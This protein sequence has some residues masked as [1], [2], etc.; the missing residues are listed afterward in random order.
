VTEY[1]PRR[2]RPRL[3]LG[4]RAREAR[5]QPAPDLRRNHKRRP[6]SV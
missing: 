4:R 2:L 6:G 5:E 1:H 3:L